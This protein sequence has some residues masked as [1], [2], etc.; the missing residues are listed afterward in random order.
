MPAKTEE[1][2]FSAKI[3]ATAMSDNQYTEEIERY[4]NGEMT[5]EERA[6]FDIL[7]KGN[8]DINSQVTEHKHFTGL[9]RQYG[10]R[11]ELEGRLDAIHQEIDVH[12][13]SDE[14]MVH[15][16]LVVQLWRNHHSKISVAASI[17]IFAVL[18][19]LFFTGYLSNRESNYKSLRGEVAKISRKADIINDKFNKLHPSARSANNQGKFRGTGFA[20]SS[21]GY[22]V[23]NYH[24]VNNADS[25][26]VQN[27]DGKSFRT[28]VVYTE[29]QSDIAIL[30]ITD[31][32]FRNLNAI[33]YSIRK[34]ESEIGENVFT[35]GYPGNAMVLGPG[36]L[37]ASTGFNGDTTAYQVSIPVDYGNSGGPL[38]DSKGNLIGIINAKQSQVEGAHFAVKSNYLLNAIRN[39]PS[40]SLTKTLNI[41]TRNTLSGLSLKQQYKKLQ[42]YIF[43]VRVYN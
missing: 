4:L 40:D 33:P 17:A 38:L 19:T 37:T 41:N 29:P 24:V 16:S 7:R 5:T 13:L 43:L 12:A 2:I 23:T 14:M 26:Y 20:L 34:W 42:N 25:V 3:G 6:R 18:G 8:A 35:I 39:I 31:S 36:F 28:R 9:I 10:E 1:V 27:A 21:N 32:T 15:P 22:L 30:Q 11:L